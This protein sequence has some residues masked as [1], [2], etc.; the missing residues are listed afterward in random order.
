MI[1]PS[2]LVTGGAHGDIPV[3]LELRRLGLRVITSGNRH[4]DL[5]HRF[6]DQ[7]VACD[8][9]DVQGIVSIANANKVLAIIPSCHDAAVGPASEAA[10]I[11]G[12]PNGH[13]KPEVAYQIHRKD[14]IRAF[15]TSIGVPFPMGQ[16]SVGLKTDQAIAQDLGPPL[17]VKPTGLAGGRGITRVD[18]LSELSGATSFARRASKEQRVLIEQFAD[19]TNHAASCLIERG[20]VALTFFDDEYYLPGTFRV[21]GAHSVTSLSQSEQDFI[22]DSAQ[23]MVNG[24]HLVDGLLHMQVI[25]Q[26]GDIKF[27]ELTR[28]LPG[29]LYPWL[30]EESGIRGY[31]RTAIKSYLPGNVSFKGQVIPNRYLIRHVIRA[32]AFG[33]FTGVP[34]PPMFAHR[35]TKYYPLASLGE[36]V[37]DP[38]TW[39]AGVA[40]IQSTSDLVES[41]IRALS[42]GGFMAELEP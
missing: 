27:I 38:S 6:G 21:T 23:M 1:R 26:P 4:S 22:I 31:T 28:R 20:T 41:D 32:K 15:W 33:K 14:G 39:A 42:R 25:R 5:G 30:V 35:L 17:I 8:Y 12:I 24:L 11:L 3:L 40:F 29:D 9:T 13:D 36:S 34:I 19:G 2:V 7:Y 10:H 18:S 37:E 16:V